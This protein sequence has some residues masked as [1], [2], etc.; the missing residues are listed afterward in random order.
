MLDNNN[1]KMLL[2]K[3]TNQIMAID[4]IDEIRQLNNSWL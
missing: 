2:E 1:R 4:R 3:T